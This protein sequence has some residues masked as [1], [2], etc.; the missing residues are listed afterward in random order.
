M[1]NPNKKKRLK[2]MSLFITLFIISSLIML[3][4]GK[5]EDHFLRSQYLYTDNYA[6]SVN[7]PGGLEVSKVPQFIVFG[8]D[9]QC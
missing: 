4:S 6:P 9:G 2:V 3:M 5:E 1:S 8:F 7:P